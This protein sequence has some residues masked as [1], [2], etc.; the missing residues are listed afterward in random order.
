[1]GGPATI[2]SAN[3]PGQVTAPDGSP[4]KTG[5]Q[6]K[7]QPAVTP[8]S[9]AACGPHERE[10]K[11]VFDDIYKFGR[12][13]ARKLGAANG[14][15]SQNAE[16]RAPDALA[17]D[18]FRDHIAKAFAA[19]P[20][21]PTPFMHANLASTDE[22]F[23]LRE[24]A[25]AHLSAVSNGYQAIKDPAVKAAA[26]EDSNYR[27]S[28]YSAASWLAGSPKRQE[29]QD[30]QRYKENLIL[31]AQAVADDPNIDPD[32]KKDFLNSLAKWVQTYDVDLLHEL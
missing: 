19:C 23:I 11:A 18:Q 10:D 17:K 31:R 22:E 8:G 6:A 30:Y 7:S 13:S 12:A 32:I 15:Q 16:R 1:M 20:Y 2:P 21:R 24:Q 27:R 4:A 5:A 3:R 29:G 25:V 14:E 28:I 26:R 9:L